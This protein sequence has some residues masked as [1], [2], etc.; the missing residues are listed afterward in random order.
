MTFQALRGG[1]SR[2]DPSSLMNITYEQSHDVSIRPGD[3]RVNFKETSP[4]Y[5]SLLRT[6]SIPRLDLDCYT[7]H[8][9]KGKTS[10]R[11]NRSLGYGTHAFLFGV[12][13]K[14][15]HDWWIVCQY[16]AELPHEELLKQSEADTA[17]DAYS[18]GSI[19]GEMVW[20]V[21]ASRMRFLL[22]QDH[23]NNMQAG[24]GP[25]SGSGAWILDRMRLKRTP[26]AFR[27]IDDN[28][29]QMWTAVT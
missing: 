2:P 8:F 19:N 24:V 3:P 9:R 7:S 23:I 11:I 29:F 28:A 1:G 15:G 17:F 20:Q 4:R 13:N 21:N 27:I 6:G 26:G 12:R 16:S 22:S 5:L 10:L 18:L 25:F 14:G